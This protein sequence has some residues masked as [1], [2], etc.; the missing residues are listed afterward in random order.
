MNSR[1]QT[2]VLHDIP[3]VSEFQ[4]L[5]DT[6]RFG[7]YGRYTGGPLSESRGM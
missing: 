4:T 5:V 7:S 1:G 6:E 2:W 3:K